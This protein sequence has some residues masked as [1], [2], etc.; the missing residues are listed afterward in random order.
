V[1]DD[2]G[3]FD[4]DEVVTQKQM[5]DHLFVCLEKLSHDRTRSSCFGHGR[6]L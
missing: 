2:A 5:K 3:E 6:S 4:L 1:S